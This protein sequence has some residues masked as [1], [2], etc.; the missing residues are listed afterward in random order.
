MTGE[1]RVVVFGCGHGPKLKGGDEAKAAFV[2]LPCI[3]MLPPPFIDYVLSRA[4]A[5]GVFLAG[6]A[7]SNC[8]NRFGV[9][10]TDAR[11]DRER[12]PQLR[13]R[14]PRPRVRRFWAGR[15]ESGA[16]G[17]A[18]RQFGKELGSIETV[19]PELKDATSARQFGDR[20][21]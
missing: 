19:E 7:S 13:R 9:E 14:V 20:T 6:C 12:D 2:E 5:D 4:L 17:E 10:W 16:L 18:V 15:P 11:V 21:Q 8:Y 3:G 1:N